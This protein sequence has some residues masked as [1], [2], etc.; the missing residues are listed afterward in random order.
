MTCPSVMQA[1]DGSSAELSLDTRSDGIRLNTWGQDGTVGFRL[2][3]RW[4][5]ALTGILTINGATRAVLSDDEE[6]EF[7]VGLPA[8]SAGTYDCK[9]VVG[10]TVYTRTIHTIGARKVLF[11]AEVTL[12][13]RTDIRLASA[14][15]EKLFYD[16]QWTEG[17]TAT[18]ISCADEEIARG[19]VGSCTWLPRL[20]G[21]N[22]LSLSLQPAI[23]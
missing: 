7:V 14:S 6:K 2:S 17:A 1:M 23:H 9:W 16:A 3:M 19:V 11:G 8:N 21:N 20:A 18:V 13:T 12:D 15:G 4:G 5:N 10:E 22:I